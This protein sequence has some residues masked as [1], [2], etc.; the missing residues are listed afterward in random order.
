MFI[1]YFGGEEIDE[2]YSFQT[3]PGYIKVVQKI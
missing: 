1:V 2:T 3:P